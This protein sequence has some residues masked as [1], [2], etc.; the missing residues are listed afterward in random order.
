MKPEFHD[1]YLSK[2]IDPTGASGCGF[3]WD[4]LY[5]NLGEATDGELELEVRLALGFRHVFRW[6]STQ[7]WREKT[8]PV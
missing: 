7:T 1:E 4:E 5:R 6:C 8:P 3:D 2:K